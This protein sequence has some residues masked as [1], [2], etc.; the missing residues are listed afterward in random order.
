MGKALWLQPN[1][2]TM[3]Y[4]FEQYKNGAAEAA[5]FLFAFVFYNERAAVIV[6][7]VIVPAVAV[8]LPFSTTVPVSAQAPLE[9]INGVC[10]VL[11]IVILHAFPAVCEQ[12]PVT[13]THCQTL[14]LS[15]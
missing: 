2:N 7:S 4:I 3:Y 13:F 12:L 8:E 9:G 15:T 5:L 6:A 11:L 10:I 1:L 14:D